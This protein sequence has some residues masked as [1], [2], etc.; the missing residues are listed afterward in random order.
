MTEDPRF[1]D[2]YM[3]D[4]IAGFPF[5]S[6]PRWN[7]VITT[8]SNGG[9]NVNQA[10]KHPLLRF[11]APEGVRCWDHVGDLH[12]FW[13]A[14]RG[15]KYTFPLTDP[16]DACSRRMQAPGVFPDIF[17]TDQVLGV[18]D[19]IT[20]EFQL[21]KAYTFGP[22]TYT[23]PIYHPQVDSVL[24][25]ANAKELDDATLTG[26]PYTF[27]TSRLTGKVVFDHAPADGLALTAGFRFDV[28]SRWETDDAYSGL[29]SA[30][31]T[32][33]FADLSFVEVPPC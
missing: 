31:R 7:N 23:R 1:T 19:G 6:T 32:A 24:I 9:E 13:M 30:F 16:L 10:W 26:H 2:I 11:T 22:R 3:P 18:G 14:M 12:E 4:R 21:T 20:T 28:E 15:T 5:V 17:P 27:E 25:M 33:G 29:V 8:V